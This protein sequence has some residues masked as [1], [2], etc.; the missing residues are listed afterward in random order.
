VATNKLKPSIGRLEWR[1]S[2]NSKCHVATHVL[3]VPFDAMTTT[4]P[5]MGGIHGVVTDHEYEIVK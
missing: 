4:E 2:T 5:I 1:R 3:V